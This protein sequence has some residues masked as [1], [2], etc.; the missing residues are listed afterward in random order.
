MNHRSKVLSSYPINNHVSN[1][2]NSQLTIIRSLSHKEKTLLNHLKNIPETEYHKNERRQLF[3]RFE[4][5][6]FSRIFIAN[7][8]MRNHG[9][10]IDE[11][12]RSIL[13]VWFSETSILASF[14]SLSHKNTIKSWGHYSFFFEPNMLQ[15]TYPRQSTFSKS[16]AFRQKPSSKIRHWD[17]KLV[18][19]ISILGWKP[20]L[21]RQKSSSSDLKRWN[22]VIKRTLQHTK[23]LRESFLLVEKQIKIQDKKN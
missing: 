3:W 20:S 19:N 4:I 18:R 17:E 6:S 16:I 23:C 1:A 14:L 12:F 13:A 22:D 21:S 11:N 5:I 8:L 10:K 7:I 15:K 9:R 2:K